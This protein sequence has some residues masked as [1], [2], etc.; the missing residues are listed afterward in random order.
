MAIELDGNYH[1]DVKEYDNNREEILK[2]AKM[3]ILR[4]TNVEVLDNIE[5]TLKVIEETVI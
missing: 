1:S 3:K 4:F 2:S 5:I